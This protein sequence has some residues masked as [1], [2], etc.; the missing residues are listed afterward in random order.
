[1]FA[2]VV[3]VSSVG[4]EDWRKCEPGSVVW[5]FNEGRPRVRHYPNGGDLLVHRLAAVAW[6]GWDA[7]AGNEVHHRVP[8]S[9]LNVES[10][11]MPIPTE[12]HRMISREHQVDGVAESVV[13][14]VVGGLGGA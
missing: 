11:L 13:Q 5:E 4:L 6:Y 12:E 2:G 1:M 7:V 8:V 9:W 14:S 3:A 10:N